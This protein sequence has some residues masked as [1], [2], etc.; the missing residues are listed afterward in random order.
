[1]LFSTERWISLKDYKPSLISIRLKSLK[2]ILSIYF[3]WE[4]LYRKFYFPLSK[5]RFS[6]DLKFYKQNAALGWNFV[7]K[8]KVIF[9]MVL[10]DMRLQG[11]RQK[12][13]AYMKAGSR[14]LT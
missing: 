8:Q 4:I 1:M 14:L 6:A 13:T 10:Q 7:F 12:R 11:I 9:W 5:R 3:V 2:E